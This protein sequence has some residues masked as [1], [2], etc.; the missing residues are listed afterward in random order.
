MSLDEVVREFLATKPDSGHPDQPIAER[1]AAIRIGSDALFEKFGANAVND[2]SINEFH[3]DRGDEG[4]R[5]RVYR[6]NDAATGLPIHVFLHGGGWWL[7]SADE[8]VNDAM[9]R[10]RSHG[11]ACLVVAV[12]YRLAP[13]HPFPTPVEDCYA[14]LLWAVA[15]ATEIGGDPGNVS[16]GGVSAGANLAAAVSL[17]ARDRGGPQL[18][19]KLLEV[20]PL[21]LTLDTMRASGIGDAY[22]ITVDEMQLSTDLYL[23]S[24]HDARSQLASPL[25]APSVAGLPPARIMTAEFDPLRMDGERYAASLRSAGVPV[26]HTVY[27]G[28]VHGSLALTGVWPPAVAWQRD[29]I[30]SLRT[31]HARERMD[32]PRI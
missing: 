27:P 15:N 5:V 8:L 4:I 9:C 31:V 6:P 14:G 20:P 12:D 2:V 29:V 19:L 26:S 10:E 21:D 22:G 30:A 28:A 1:R 16:V 7:G 17:L 18:R 24:P 3:I 11:V 23:S 32:G 25:L 13:E